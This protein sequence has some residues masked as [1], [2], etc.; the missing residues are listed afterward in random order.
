MAVYGAFLVVILSPPS[1]ST[2]LSTRSR[3]QFQGK[4]PPLPTKKIKKVTWSKNG[5][6][7]KEM[8]FFCFTVKR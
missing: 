2:L 6:V 1:E 5:Q 3:L 4:I 7:I 8:S